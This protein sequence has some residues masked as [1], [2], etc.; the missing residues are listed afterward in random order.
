MLLSIFGLSQIFP[1]LPKKYIYLKA[2]RNMCS[3]IVCP[4]EDTENLNF[5]WKVSHSIHVLVLIFKKHLKGPSSI[6]RCV[7]YKKC[8]CILV[9]LISFKLFIINVCLC[10]K[11]FLDTS[12]A[13]FMPSVL[14]GSTVCL[15]YFHWH[16]IHSLFFLSFPLTAENHRL[17][18]V[19]QSCV[20]HQVSQG[21][22]ERSVWE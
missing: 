17:V 9:Y 7:Y 13:L 10:P 21:M 5:D 3:Y 18:P 1:L 19:H 16:I 12:L 6:S 15:S 20:L 14:P 4:Q 11:S 8:L 22:S 2:F